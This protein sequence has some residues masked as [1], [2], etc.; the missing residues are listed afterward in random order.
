M[1][2]SM[3]I[4][5]LA[6][7]PQR[8]APGQRFRFE[9]YLK[10]LALRGIHVDVHSLLDPDTARIL[11]RTGHAGRKAAFLVRGAVAR[12]R[13]LAA[14]DRYD[15][16]FIFR[17]AYPLGFPIIERALAGRRI[18]Y[19]I[20]FDDA[21]W[22]TNAS[23]ANRFIAPLKFS[24]KTATI[25]RHAALVTVGNEYLAT[26]ARRIHSQVRVIPTTIDT[27]LYRPR[28]S[29]GDG[30][31]C[32]GWSGSRTTAKHLELVGPVMAEAQ[33]RHGVRLRVI[34]V[35]DFE[36]PRAEVENL[37]WREE[38]ELEDLS[39]IDIG[40]M[41]LPDDEWARGK[42]G[43][44]ALQYMALGIPTVMSPVGVNREIAEGGAA[45]LASEPY[46]WRVALD[47]LIGDTAARE[48]MG[49]TGRK[50]VE[51]CYSVTANI[52]AYYDALR[53]AANHA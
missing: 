8:T 30:P 15:L 28:N 38:T 51:K 17:E 44:K 16:V 22:L 12:L 11:Y 25:V 34:G 4:L 2:Q 52:D 18:P 5:L 36:L 13:D 47:E 53:T 24:K 42:C 50:R 6:P 21:I 23:H 1:S 9:Q 26:W 48:K 32:I 37:P 40:I 19:L 43:L 45:R 10:P 41:P 27:N 46:A 20:D 49:R 33:R 3:R 29:R 7:Y 14:A 31:L 39:E 35:E